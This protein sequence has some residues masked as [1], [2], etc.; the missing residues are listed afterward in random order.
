[1]RPCQSDV[2]SEACE[3][4]VRLTGMIA[5]SKRNQEEMRA[6]Q[7]AVIARVAAHVD[8]YFTGDSPEWISGLQMPPYSWENDG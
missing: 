6:E 3:R 8:G 4:N 5:W 1:M 7:R 2:I